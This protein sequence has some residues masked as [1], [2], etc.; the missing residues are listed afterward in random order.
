M[1]HGGAWATP[2]KEVE[3]HRDGVARAA[4]I[5]FEVLGGGGSSVDAVGEAVRLMED[6]TAFNA[7]HGAVL[8]QVGEVELDAAIMEGATLGVGAVAA[9]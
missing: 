5:G 2:A 7:G 3:P 6:D 4:R 9:V 8:N 1:V